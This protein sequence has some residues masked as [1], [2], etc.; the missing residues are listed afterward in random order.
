MARK[1]RASSRKQVAQFNP[2]NVGAI[3]LALASNISC[4][5]VPPAWGIPLGF[6]GLCMWLYG[7]SPVKSWITTNYSKRPRLSIIVAVLA[8][9]VASTPAIEG[10][11]G[12]HNKQQA[13]FPLCDHGSVVFSG[14]T[15]EDMSESAATITTPDPCVTAENNVTKRSKN[16]VVINGAEA[17]HEKK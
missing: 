17:G 14:N 7:L 6:A 8:L 9:A 5:L 3:V 15:S 10:W 2:Q 16:G 12:W 11:R 4:P 13:S 1:K